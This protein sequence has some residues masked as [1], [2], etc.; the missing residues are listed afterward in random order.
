MRRL[1]VRLVLA[2]ELLPAA[3]SAAVTLVDVGGAAPPELLRPNDPP[4][5]Y[6]VITDRRLQGAFVR[7]AQE[8]RQRGLQAA[9]VTLQAID[10]G[11]PDGV[12]LAERIRLFLRDAHANWGTHWVLL[13]GDA[14]V[15]PMR[16]ARLRLGGSLGDI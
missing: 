6:L 13:G 7:L 12:D 3:A 4:V 5:P 1:L 15:V 9:V 8:R 11:Y 14:S 2:L 10:S 16:R